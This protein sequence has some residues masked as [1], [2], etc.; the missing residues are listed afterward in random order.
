MK[1]SEMPRA[2]YML[3]TPEMAQKWLDAN[4]ECNRNVS[5]SV[6]QNYFD[7][8]NR[9]DWNERNGETI[10]FDTTGNMFDGQHR[11]WAV[12]NSK[13]PLWFLVAFNCAP[14]SFK[15]VDSG[16]PRKG[17][18]IL[19]I[20]GTHN[21]NVTAGALTLLW[22]YQNGTIG[23]SHKITNAVVARMLEDHP[24]MPNSVSFAISNRGPR[25]FLAPSI[26]AFIHYM[27]K[28]KSGSTKADAF[29][30]GV[31]L[32][33]PCEFDSAIRVLRHRLID[34]VASKAKIPRNDLLAM[35]IK[36]W[37]AY[38]AKETNCSVH[39][40]RYRA[41]GECAEK[42]PLFRG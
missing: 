20:I 19:S 32:G 31:I 38:I 40:I 26:V 41:V 11:L 37:N 15:S 1:K 13:K 33:E 28:R 39:R 22:R 17:G 14:D 34:N 2:E 5:E 4:I 12:V 30:K 36:A 9:G 16:K 18:D 7:A 27:A 3:V 23:G 25:G 29:I 35:C 6:V 42:F 10:K 8:I 21:C 24:Q